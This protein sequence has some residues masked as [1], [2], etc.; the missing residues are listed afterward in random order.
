[1]TTKTLL[2]FVAANR[3]SERVFQRGRHVGSMTN[4]EVELVEFLKIADTRFVK[5]VVVTKEI[6]LAHMTLTEAIQDG[7]RNV[8]HTIGNRVGD[9]F[10]L[11]GELVSVVSVFESVTTA[12]REYFAIRRDF[13]RVGHRR[14]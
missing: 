4:R 7:R 9:F 8:F 1:M 12:R 5:N 3:A 2:W 14:R 13:E 10:C 11:A 6:C